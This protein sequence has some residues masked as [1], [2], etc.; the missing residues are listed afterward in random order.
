M[1]IIVLIVFTVLGFIAFQCIVL[2]A[3]KSAS[4][5]SNMAGRRVVCQ[6]SNIK[7]PRSTLKR[8]GT[9]GGVG[10]I[11]WSGR[12]FLLRDRTLTAPALA[13]S[14]SEGR[15]RQ[16]ARRESPRRGRQAGTEERGTAR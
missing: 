1:Y 5:I 14:E 6:G 11:I 9:D 4:S 10:K 15:A 7:R 16:Q 8:H 13:L 3:A 12:P 2:L